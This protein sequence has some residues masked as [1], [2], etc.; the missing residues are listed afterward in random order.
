VKDTSEFNITESVQ[1]VINMQE[2]QASSRSVK[3]VPHF[4]GFPRKNGQQ[5][6]LG[7]EILDYAD[8]DMNLVTDETRLQQAI[9]NLQSNAL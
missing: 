4:Y 6:L 2:H 3:I 1:E 8:H 9:F 5:T 7:A